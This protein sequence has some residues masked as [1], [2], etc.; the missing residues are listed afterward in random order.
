MVLLK[1]LYQN[2]FMP[3]D[4]VPYITAK[5]VWPFLE[6]KRKPAIQLL[7]HFL[8][9]LMMLLLLLLCFIFKQFFF[10]A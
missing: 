3:H 4:S 2:H 5:D 7:S 10:T 1:K 6:S 9:Q 8:L